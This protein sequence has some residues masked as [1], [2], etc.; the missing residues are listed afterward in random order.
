MLKLL[1]LIAAYL[2]P[3]FS[4]SHED[5]GEYEADAFSV[6]SAE[7]NEIILE[8]L[9]GQEPERM[10]RATSAYESEQGSNI[11]L[12][13]LRN[14]AGVVTTAYLYKAVSHTEGDGYICRVRMDPRS[15]VGFY[16]TIIW[17]L[18]FIDP[19]YRPTITIPPPKQ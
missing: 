5:R 14:E 6:S 2:A 15:K 12:T 13:T 18:T 17:C 8:Q 9:I 19:A 4:F 3:T 16:Q 11:A 7:E 1:L 10:V